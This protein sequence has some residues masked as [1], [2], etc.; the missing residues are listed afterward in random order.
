LNI[1]TTLR[2]DF[3][4]PL[5]ADGSQFQTISDVFGSMDMGRLVLDAEPAKE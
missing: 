3:T 4:E 2:T 5:K 1:R